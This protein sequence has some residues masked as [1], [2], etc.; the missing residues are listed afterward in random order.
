MCFQAVGRTSRSGFSRRKVKPRMHCGASEKTRWGSRLTHSSRRPSSTSKRLTAVVEKAEA[1]ESRVSPANSEGSGRP[2]PGQVPQRPRAE[3]DRLAGAPV[4]ACGNGTWLGIT[5]APAGWGEAAV[6]VRPR[7]LNFPVS[8]R[9]VE[10]LGGFSRG[11]LRPRSRK[12]NRR[13]SPDPKRRIRFAF[14]APPSLSPRRW[15]APRAPHP[16]R[17][18][19]SPGQRVWVAPAL[20]AV[21]QVDPRLVLGPASLEI[22][23]SL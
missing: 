9:T 19:P 8:R 16:P 1:G 21:F 12:S 17:G 6:C 23:R 5:N 4:V 13:T 18:H 3:R 20:A 10:R 7:A 22:E 15:M 2:L 14:L 11:A